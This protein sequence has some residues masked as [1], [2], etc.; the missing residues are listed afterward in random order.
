MKISI[1]SFLFLCLGIFQPI[2]PYISSKDYDV[3]AFHRSKQSSKSPKRV[4]IQKFRAL[5]EVYEEASA[6]TSGSK[7]ERANRTTTVSGTKTS[8]GVQLSGVDIPDFQKIVDDA[9]ADFVAQLEAD[10]FEI[11]SADE[12]G[13]TDY[14][15][16]YTKIKGGAS[17]TDQATGYVM[18]TPT[19]YDYWVKAVSS[20]GRE[21]GT[22]TDTSSKLSKDLDDAYVAEATFIFPFVNLD[23]SST[24]F[25]NYASSKVKADINLRLAASVGTL[26]NEQMSL[27]KFA[28]GLTTSP[29]QGALASQVR[30]VAGHMASSPLFDSSTGLKRD[31]Y[32]SEIFEDTKLVEVTSAEVATFSKTAYPQLVMVSGGELNLA[33]HYVSCDKQNYI[34]SAKGSIEELIGSGISNFKTLIKD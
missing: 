9:Y 32:F 25:A 22:F 5:F 6:S 13:K 26:D 23:A 12:A 28:K 29:T 21:K 2:E 15:S 18:V 3:N 30:F 20:N 31:V 19:G 24:S 1:L 16:G 8:M 17:S 11:I 34:E 27:G 14:Y 33:S 4:Y 7:N 10:G